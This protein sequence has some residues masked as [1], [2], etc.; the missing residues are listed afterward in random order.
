LRHHDFISQQTIDG[1]AKQVTCKSRI[2]FKAS[3]QDFLNG[4]SQ[5]TKT[6]PP[7]EF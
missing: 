2:T 3:S 4:F 7:H 6:I 1:L 5:S